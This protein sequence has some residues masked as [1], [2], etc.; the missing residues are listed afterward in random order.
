MWNLPPVFQPWERNGYTW[1]YNQLLRKKFGFKKESF[2]FL[3]LWFKISLYFYRKK[4]S[5]ILILI[6]GKELPTAKIA[7]DNIYKY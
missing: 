7:L 6:S 2:V 1:I 5:V 4:P 3:F